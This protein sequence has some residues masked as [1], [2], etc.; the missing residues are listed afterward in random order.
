MA[1]LQALLPLQ[2]HWV[3]LLLGCK[4][5]LDLQSISSWS[6]ALNNRKLS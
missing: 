1:G 6:A 3:V 2:Q 5:E 4:F